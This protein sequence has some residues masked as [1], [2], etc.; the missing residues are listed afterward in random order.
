MMAL[1]LPGCVSLQI[2]SGNGRPELIGFGSVSTLGGANGRVLQ[3]VAPGLS[4]RWGPAAPGVSLGW[5]ETR[6]F[7]PAPVTGTNAPTA[8]AIQTKCYG[9]DLAPT[10]FMAGFES[11]FAVPLP[12]RGRDVIQYIAYSENHPDQTVVVRKETK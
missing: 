2:P 4:L 11:R 1:L 6:F 5:H 9:L 12:E 10:H 7:Y 8:A 3:I